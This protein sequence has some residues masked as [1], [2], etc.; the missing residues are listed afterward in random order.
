[1]SSAALPW[2]DGP[3]HYLRQAA[4]MYGGGRLD[5]CRRVHVRDAGGTAA[6]GSV[7]SAIV[8]ATTTTAVS[9][10]PIPGAGPGVA[11]L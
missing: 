1:V 9:H 8:S 11:V 6:G 3:R 7:R 10:Q 2:L 5:G 4:G